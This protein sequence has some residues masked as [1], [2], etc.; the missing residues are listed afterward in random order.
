MKYAR[1]VETDL[2]NV[3]ESASS[4]IPGRALAKILVETLFQLNDDVLVEET[5]KRLRFC[6]GG[7]KDYEKQEG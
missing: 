3:L 4:A 2:R 6:L 5:H 1:D 7:K